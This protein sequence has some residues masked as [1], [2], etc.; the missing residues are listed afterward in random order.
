MLMREV[1]HL[2]ARYRG[3]FAPEMIER[4]LFESYTT[5]GR[6]ARVRT[7]LAA[8]A[9]HFA[10]DRL[11]ALAQSMG[12]VPKNR[13]EVLFVCVENAGRSQLAAA[14]L[15]K[16][17]GAS[18]S[19]RSAGSTPA[20]ELHPVTLYLMQERGLPAESL[21]PKPLTDDVVR[22]AD[23]VVTMGC[24]DACPIYPDKQYTDW[25]LPDLQSVDEAGAEAVADDIERRVA[26]L[27]EELRKR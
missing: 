26:E 24:G 4:Y 22:A 8:T 17:A 11:R 20:S 12:E 10:A 3:I 19:V 2:A 27:W 7:Y 15:R 14:F 16:T 9:M 1:D 25:Q 6:S 23:V 21:Y 18:V 5:L 13:P